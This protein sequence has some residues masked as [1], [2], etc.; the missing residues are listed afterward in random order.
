MLNGH[1]CCGVLKDDLVIRVGPCRY[2]EALAEPHVQPMNFTGRSLRGFA[3]VGPGGH[4]KDEG[5]MK[6]IKEATDF[7]ASLPSKESYV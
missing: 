1:M 6:W 4:R 5:L 2:E 3:F 7:A